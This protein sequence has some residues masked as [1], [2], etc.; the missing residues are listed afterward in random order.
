MG[1]LNYIVTLEINI[2]YMYINLKG[3]YSKIKFQYFS[4]KGRDN[5]FR[6]Q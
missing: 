3:T 4:Q 2:I 1:I 6:D 5:F